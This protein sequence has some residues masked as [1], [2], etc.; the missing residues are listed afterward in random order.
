MMWVKSLSLLFMA[1]VWALS[2]VAQASATQAWRFKVYLDDQEI[3]QH[4]F[5]VIEQDNT[6]YVA[7]QASFDVTVL[8]FTAYRYQH[9]NFEVWQGDCLQAIQSETND[10]GENEFVQGQMNE[11][12]LRLHTSQG[13]EQF[14]G[15]IKT[16]AY[17]DPSFLT[18][19]KLL[20]SQ[21]GELLPVDTIDLGKVEIDV[22][23]KTIMARRYRVITDQFSIDL[24]YSLQREWLALQST[25][26]DGAVLRYQR[27]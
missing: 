23:G 7:V 3:G 10:N 20:N 6:R 9:S 17:W 14:K 16:F 8:F 21:T 5:K 22:H 24:W 1:S 15:C 25:T 12:V 27:Q 11:N 4:T 13:E 19:K 26:S 2:T 18:S